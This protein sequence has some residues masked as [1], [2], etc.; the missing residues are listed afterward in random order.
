MRFTRNLLV[1]IFTLG[2]L[3]T[4]LASKQEAI[5]GIGKGMDDTLIQSKSISDAEQWEISWAWDLE[6]SFE[7]DYGY[8]EWWIQAG[9]MEFTGEH[10]GISDKLTLYQIKPILRLYPSGKEDSFFIEAG[11]GAAK[12]SKKSFEQIVI[13]TKGNFVIHA[14]LGWVLGESSKLSLRYS[15][16]SN[17]YTHTPNPGIDSLAINYHWNFE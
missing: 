2:F 4:A 14:A 13:Q 6:Q 9:Y 10:Q 7:S 15:H 17:G 3:N 8:A 1:L 12:L 11:L 16:Y 5:L